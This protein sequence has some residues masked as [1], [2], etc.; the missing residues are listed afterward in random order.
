MFKE[1]TG[2]PVTEYINMA[3][4][5][6]AKELL[7]NTSLKVYEIAYE[8]GFNDQHYFSSVFKKIVGLSPTEYRELV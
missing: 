1:E 6:K 8:V 7:A 4:I 5:K 3:R 2:I